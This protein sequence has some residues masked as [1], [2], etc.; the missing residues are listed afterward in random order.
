MSHL[1]EYEKDAL[2]IDSP[3]PPLDRHPTTPKKV[4]GVAA[5][6]DQGAP[7]AITTLLRHQ[8]SSGARTRAATA[9]TTAAARTA[10]TTATSAATPSGCVTVTSATAPTTERTA[11]LWLLIQDFA[12][13]NLAHA[14]WVFLSSS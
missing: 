5:G 11:A 4:A 3:L 9:A 12:K 8:S 14:H 1:S 13:F 6:I 10:A 7:T 2:G